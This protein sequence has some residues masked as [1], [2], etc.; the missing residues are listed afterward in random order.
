MFTDHPEAVNIA[1]MTIRACRIAVEQC[2]AYL[3]AQ[4]MPHEPAV[5]TC[6]HLIQW[7]RYLPRPK[8]DGARGVGDASVVQRYRRIQAFFKWMV[9]PTRFA[10]VRWRRC[11]RRSSPRSWHPSSAMVTSMDSSRNV[12]G[13]HS[14]SAATN[15]CSRRSSTPAC[16]SPRCPARD[17]DSSTHGG[18]F[19]PG[20]WGWQRGP[21]RRRRG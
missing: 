2:G 9:E 16:V 7:M 4:G 20:N 19:V 5:V 17:T 21:C 18:T 15:R 6:E 3:D 12:A 1:L 11:G 13:N 10:R 14:K 8:T